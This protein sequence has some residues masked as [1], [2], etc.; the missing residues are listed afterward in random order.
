MIKILLCLGQFIRVSLKWEVCM[1]EGYIGQI[2]VIGIMRVNLKT[3]TIFLQTTLKLI[4]Y[5]LVF[6]AGP[7][8]FFSGGKFGLGLF[9]KF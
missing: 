8:N 6:E 2:H 1:V 9:L 3:Q 5:F 4:C 7:F